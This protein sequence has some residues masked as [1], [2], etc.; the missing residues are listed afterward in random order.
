MPGNRLKNQEKIIFPIYL[1]SSILYTQ[2]CYPF[3]LDNK[4]NAEKNLPS[5]L[6]KRSYSPLNSASIMCYQIYDKLLL[7]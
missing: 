5:M 6:I 2:I 3:Y 1:F 4:E 7:T